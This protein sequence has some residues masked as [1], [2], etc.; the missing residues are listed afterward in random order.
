ML[1]K[2]PNNIGVLVLGIVSIPTCMCYGIIGMACGII[3]LVL[4]SQGMKAY[5]ANPEEFDAAGLGNMKAG[6][7]CAIIG[8]CLSALFLIYIIFIIATV[9]MGGL[10]SLSE[11]SNR[12]Y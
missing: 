11:L 9:G 10:E 3:A 5:N 12:G 6:K 2:V 8:M 4:H 7:I 1:R